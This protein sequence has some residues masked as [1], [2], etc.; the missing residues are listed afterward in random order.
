MEIEKFAYFVLGMAITGFYY[1]I[2]YLQEVR[3]IRR[4][5]FEYKNAF[6][7]EL[8]RREDLGNDQGI[9]H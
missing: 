8:K 7:A 9:N 2:I 1:E 4:I 5:F 3:F 6:I